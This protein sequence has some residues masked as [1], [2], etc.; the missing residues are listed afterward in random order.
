MAGKTVEPRVPLTLQK[1]RLKAEEKVLDLD[2]ELVSVQFNEAGRYALRLTVENPLLEGS[3]AGVQLR[4]NEGDPLYT[5]T[6]TTDIVE[7][8]NLNEVYAFEKRQFLFTLPRGFCKNDKNHDARLRIEALRL[9]GSSLRTSV[10][11]GEAFF[12]IYPRTNQPRMNL[13]ASRDEDL[14][15]YGDIM[16]LLR[17]GSDDLAM[18]C[19]RLAYAVSFHEHRPV[20]KKQAPTS[21]LPPP[22]LKE[23]SLPAGTSSLAPSQ[24]LPIPQKIH[25]TSAPEPHPWP[26][27]ES[28]TPGLLPSLPEPQQE[29]SP[30]AMK[31]FSD[32]QLSSLPSSSTSSSPAL[33][34]RLPSDARLRLPSPGYSP[35]LLFENIF[36]GVLNM[37]MPLS[38]D[39]DDNCRGPD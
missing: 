31:E 25:P 22:K 14:Y 35:E 32:E 34:R 3:G 28:C 37:R 6:A 20:A 11:A 17:V 23:R 12:A 36:S 26:S 7:Q 18:H 29:A 38:A 27:E 10:L 8:S 1:S 21:P 2:F 13:F 16:V 19:G 5:N 9:R 15:R 24:S 39:D 4:V 33:P 30:G